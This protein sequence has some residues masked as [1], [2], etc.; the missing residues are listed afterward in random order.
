MNMVTKKQIL[1]LMLGILFAGF[2]A[3]NSVTAAGPSDYQVSGIVTGGE[4]IFTDIYFLILDTFGVCNIKADGTTYSASE[5]SSTDADTRCKGYGL[6][7]GNFLYYVIM[8]IALA[9]L[10]FL[11]ILKEVNLFDAK[12]QK[13]IA[14]VLSLFMA[15]LGV[16]RIMFVSLMSILTGTTVFLLYIFLFILMI[17]W[18]YKNMYVEGQKHITIGNIH[19]DSMKR[20]QDTAK[21]IDTKISSAKGELTKIDN[22]IYKLITNDDGNYKDD[23]DNIKTGKYYLNLTEKRNVIKQHIELLISHRDR[24]LKEAHKDLHAIISR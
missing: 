21:K 13:Y 6:R 2:F 11:G 8:P 7:G 23:I 12:I 17:G 1:I 3:G 24:Y 19:V 4:G 10:M 5:I 9:F 22:Q 16:Y 18:G 20:S 15:P 14:L